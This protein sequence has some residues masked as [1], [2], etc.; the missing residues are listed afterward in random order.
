MLGQRNTHTAHR[1]AK[2][3]EV[4]GPPVLASLVS[5][6]KLESGNLESQQDGHTVVRSLLIV[7]VTTI[8]SLKTY[9]ILRSFFTVTF[10]HHVE[11]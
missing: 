2:C 11:R 5:Q 10:A 1:P 6:T 3:R 9:P 4:P 8:V 7:V